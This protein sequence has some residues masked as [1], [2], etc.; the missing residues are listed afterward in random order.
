MR[1][2]IFGCGIWKPSSALL[3]AS[4]MILTP[5]VEAREAPSYWE[6]FEFLLGSWE[7][8]ETAR[9]GAGRGERTYRLVVHGRYLLS[10]NRSLFE[11]QEGLPEGDDHRDWTILSYDRVRETYVVR[12]FVSEGYVNRFEL[13]PS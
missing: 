8:E 11:P 9:F 10:D 7:A 4:L 2:G 1:C 5:S 13:D 3:L 12:Q 6:P